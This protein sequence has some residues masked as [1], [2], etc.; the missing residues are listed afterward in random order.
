MKTLG[1]VTLVV[2]IIVTT[3]LGTTR[4]GRAL[5]K[6]VLFVPQVFDFRVKPLVWFTPEPMVERVTFSTPFGEGEGDLYRPPGKG[7]YAAV[8]VFLGVAPAESS[9]PRI[10][11]LGNSLARSNMVTLY[12]W[13][14]TMSDRRLEPEDVNYLVHAYQYLSKLDFVD[15]NRVGMGGFCVGASFAIIAA[16]QPQ[17]SDQVAFVNAFGPYFDIKDLLKSISSKTNYYN[18][19]IVPWEPNNLTTQVLASH[20]TQDLSDFEASTLRNHFIYNQPLEV[21]V[22]NLSTEAK[23]VHDILA[24][25]SPDNLEFHLKNIPKRTQAI[26]SEISPIHHIN[27][28]KA[29]LLI[30]HDRKDTLIPAYESRRLRDALAERGNLMHTEFG[31]FDHVTPNIRL[32]LVGT[33]KELLNF[34]RHMYSILLQAT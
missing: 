14:P 18:D 25:V 5:V 28:L 2:L 13:S 20:L 27:H 33:T 22:S 16:S 11:G 10:V 4:Q 29:R 9:D 19:M 32:G 7:P 26:M 23:A 8:L 31:L 12:Y 34:A 3:F 30:M 6:T 24:G 17:I 1:I 21:D 15:K